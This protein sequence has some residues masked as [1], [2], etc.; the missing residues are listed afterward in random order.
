MKYHEVVIDFS[1]RGMV[2]ISPTNQSKKKGARGASAD[3]RWWSKA[4]SELLGFL[5]RRPDRSLHFLRDFHYARSCLRT[6]LQQL[7]I[8]GSE[9]LARCFRLFRFDQSLLLE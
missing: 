5:S 4:D 1:W 9:G 3:Y 7:D 2:E 8:S 6:L